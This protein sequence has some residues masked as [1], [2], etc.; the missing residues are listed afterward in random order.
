LIEAFLTEVATADDAK[1]LVNGVV[2]GQRAVEDVELALQSLGDVIAPAS[3]LDHGGHKLT[4][5][6]GRAM[7]K[8]RNKE[9]E[10]G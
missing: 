2:G 5:G 1:D 8:V 6:K 7:Y 4:Q 10:L 9:K 3:W